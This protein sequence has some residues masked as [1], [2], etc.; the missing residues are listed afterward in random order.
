LEKGVDFIESSV[1]HDVLIEFFSDAGE[2]I[3][4]LTKAMCRYSKS[5]MAI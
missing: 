3:L 2:L 5:T 1:V 4:T